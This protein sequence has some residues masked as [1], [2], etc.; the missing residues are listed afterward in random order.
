M[1]ITEVKF[2]SSLLGSKNIFFQFFIVFIA[3]QHSACIRAMFVFF[4]KRK[5]VKSGSSSLLTGIV[6]ASFC[7]L[8][9]NNTSSATQY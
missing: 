7:H 4:G 3:F 9:D 8:V 2:I 1:S 6:K 5:K